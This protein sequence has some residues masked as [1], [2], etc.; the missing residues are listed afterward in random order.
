[1]TMKKRVKLNVKLRDDATK[2]NEWL[3]KIVEERNSNKN[4]KSVKFIV[5]LK[6]PPQSSA[7]R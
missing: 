5:T 3:N 1:M 7:D 2:R 4:F 6:S